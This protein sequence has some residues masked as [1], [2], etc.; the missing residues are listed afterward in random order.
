MTR[1]LYCLDTSS[2]LNSWTKHYRV[3]SFGPLWKRIEEEIESG[4]LISPPLVLTE[5]G[6]QHDD[7]YMWAKARPKLFVPWSDEL[8]LRQKEIVNAHPR[9]VDEKKGRSMCDPWVIA[10]AQIRR[11]PVVT[12]EDPSSDTRPRIPDVCRMMGIT[13]MR[14]ADLIDEIGLNL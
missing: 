1:T 12:E 5:L 11:C 2:L 4:K 13:W 3:S 9:L 6:R 10:L 7:L 14:M 8:Q